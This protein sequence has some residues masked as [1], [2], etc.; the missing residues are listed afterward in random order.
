MARTRSG[1]QTF[2]NYERFRIIDLPV[3]TDMDSDDVAEQLSLS[4]DFEAGVKGPLVG[5]KEPITSAL[6]IVAE[7]NDTVYRMKRQW[8]LLNYYVYRYIIGDGNCGWRAIIFALFEVLLRS[9]SRRSCQNQ[10]SRMEDLETLLKSDFDLEEFIYEDW[11]DSTLELLQWVADSIPCTDDAIALTQKFNDPEVAGQVIQWFRMIAGAW[12]KKHA[13]LYE[14]F[15]GDVNEYKSRHIDPH[16]AEIEEFGI[17]LLFDAVIEPAGIDVEIVYVDRSETN[18]IPNIHRYE[19]RLHSGEPKPGHRNTIRLLYSIPQGAHYDLLY[20]EQDFLENPRV[21]RSDAVEHYHEDELL[22]RES[23]LAK[24]QFGKV[25]GPGNL[26][27]DPQFSLPGNVEFPTA[28]ANCTDIFGV[29]ED[30]EKDYLFYD[31][32]VHINVPDGLLQPTEAA[33]VAPIPTQSEPIWRSRVD[34]R[35]TDDPIRTHVLGYVARDSHVPAPP[36]PQQSSSSV[37]SAQ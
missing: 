25:H 16:V 20:K 17:K 18:G 28:A 11:R 23:L 36:N 19:P 7:T 37:T 35:S 33:S 1:L 9:G 13:A 30:S 6:Q 14:G 21:L 29:H 3:P 22:Q 24:A 10:I 31:E 27:Q 2:Q 15:M 34:Q 12:L 32:R 4:E 5:L 26:L 8:I